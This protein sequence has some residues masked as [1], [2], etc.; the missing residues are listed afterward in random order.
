MKWLVL[1]LLGVTVS[2]AHGRT[3]TS[4]SGTQVEADYI[5]FKNNAVTLKKADGKTVDVGLQ[6]LSVADRE[7]VRAQQDAVQP[8]VQPAVD[9]PVYAS[10]TA[11]ASPDSANSTSGPAKSAFSSST[12]ATRNDILTEEE[13]AGLKTE[14]PNVKE[15]GKFVFSASF[16][17]QRVPEAERRRP[18]GT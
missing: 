15:T 9:R 18:G 17:P 2:V 7:F 6:F 16:F 1:V 5:G 10:P 3:W 4:T 12:G 8:A 14:M 13:I 11:A